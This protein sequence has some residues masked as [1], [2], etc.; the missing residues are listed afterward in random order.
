[1]IRWAALIAL[2]VQSVAAWT[3]RDDGSLVSYAD[4]PASVFMTWVLWAVFV[5][6]YDFIDGRLGS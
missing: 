1:M 2:E 5:R 3:R 6:A 4:L